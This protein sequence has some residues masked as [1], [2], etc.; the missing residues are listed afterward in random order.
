MEDSIDYFVALLN[1]DNAIDVA[2]TVTIHSEPRDTPE[3][4]SMGSYD[5]HINRV[6]RVI[7]GPIVLIQPLSLSVFDYYDPESDQ[8]DQ[9][10]NHLRQVR[11]HVAVHRS[12]PAN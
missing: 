11:Y 5:S 10:K 6:D 7:L 12:R 2:Q 8:D 1:I 3:I 9:V 4:K